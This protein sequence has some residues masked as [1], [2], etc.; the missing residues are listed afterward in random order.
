MDHLAWNCPTVLRPSVV[1]LSFATYVLW[2][3]GAF[4]RKTEEANRKWAM[5]NRMVTWPMTSRDPREVKVVIANT[6]SAQYLENSWYAIYWAVANYWNAVRQYG[7]LS[8]RQLGFL[9]RHASPRVGGIY[10]SYVITSGT[11]QL[12]NCS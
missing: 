10:K 12:L 9:L 5:G 7:R 11:V 6:V 1:C 8:R 2:L 4:C 3:N